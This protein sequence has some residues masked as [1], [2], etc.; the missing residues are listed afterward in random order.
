VSEAAHDTVPEGEV[1]GQDP[2]PGAILPEE[3]TVAITVSTGPEEAEEEP[4]EDVSGEGPEESSDS[5]GSGDG[6]G[7]EE[8]PGVSCS[9]QAWNP[10]TIYDQ[11]DRVH[12]GGRVYE[13]RWWI[14]GQPPNTGG[15][16]GPWSDQ[17][18]C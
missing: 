9:G 12:H 11:G 6:G 8:S 10:L 1:S 13:A 18:P 5:E 3:G 7:Q 2:E 16:W 4:E 15:E 17:G 14:Q